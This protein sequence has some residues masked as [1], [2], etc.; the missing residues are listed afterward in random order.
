[1]SKVQAVE[2]Q[3]IFGDI[4]NPKVQ[5]GQMQATF[6]DIGNPKVQAD[7]VQAISGDVGIPQAPA[8][9]DAG[10]P[11]PLA[12]ADGAADRRRLKLAGGLPAAD[13]H[14]LHHDVDSRHCGYYLDHTDRVRAEVHHRASPLEDRLQV[15][16][17]YLLQLSG[18]REP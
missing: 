8:C 11:Q 7:Q 9:A 18:P 6:G 3:D 4:G 13:P 2:V 5:A 10:L 12:A 15:G 14:I 16:R 1:M 17:V